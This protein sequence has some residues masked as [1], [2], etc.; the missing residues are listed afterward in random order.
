M[1][2]LACFPAYKSASIR[3]PS[4][5]QISQYS[6]PLLHCKS[7]STIWFPFPALR[8]SQYSARLSYMI[9]CYFLSNQQ[10]V[11]YGLAKQNGGWGGVLGGVL[12]GT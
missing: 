3:L 1:A 6:A 8:I 10:T 2:I 4:C 7:A 11:S 5:L 9:V 12:G